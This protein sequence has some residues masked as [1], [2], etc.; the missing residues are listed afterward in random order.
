MSDDDFN[1]LN[2]IQPPEPSPEAKRRAIGASLMAFDAAEEA[3]KKESAIPPQGLSW[4]ERLKSIVPHLK[5]NWI[6]DARLSI[7]TAALVLVLLPL[8][9]QLYSTTAL[10]QPHPVDIKTPPVVTT[11]PPV[12]QPVTTPTQNAHANNDALPSTPTVPAGPIAGKDESGAAVTAN[13]QPPTSGDVAKPEP[14]PEPMMEKPSAPLAKTLNEA[15][16]QP[17]NTP[18]LAD[19]DTSTANLPTDGL[20][21]VPATEAGRAQASVASGGEADLAAAPPA[22]AQ[23]SG[24][25]VMDKSMAA[26]TMAIGARQAT[27]PT[28]DKFANFTES[29]QKAVA[30]DP[31]STFSIDVDTASYSYMRRSL[32]EGRIPEPDAVRVEELLNYFPYDYPAATSA[33]TPFKPTIAVFPTPWNSKTELMQIGIKGYEPP[34]SARPVSNLVFLIDTSGSMDEPDKLPLLQRALTL[35]VNTLPAEDTVSIVSYAGAAGVVLEPTKASDKTKILNALDNLEAG[36]STAGAEGIELAYQ[37]AEAH[38]L[39]GGNNRVILATDGDFNVGI[40]DPAAL[41]TFIKA[42]RQS[43][44]SLSV[45]GFGEGN[46]DD[47]T[48][49]ALAQNG[50]G[51]ASYIDT[52]SE[53]Q[54]VLVKEAG[55][56]LDTIA[57]DVKI[58]VEFNPA[59]V[60]S[61]RL[62]GYET[63]ALNREDFNNDKVDAGDVGAGHTV[64]ALYEI[65]PAGA[66]TT[67]PVDPLRYGSNNAATP[68]AVTP[69]DGK[70]GELA[71]FKLR[72][73]L[74]GSDTSRLIEQPVGPSMVVDNIGNA[75]T[76]ARWATAVAAFGQ[77]L[78]GSDYAGTMSY[79]DIGQLARG[80][81]GTDEDGYRSEF[82]KLV[83]LAS[84][85]SGPDKPSNTDVPLDKPIVN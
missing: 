53:A 62:I 71:D 69:A 34:A 8:G 81:K 45:L 83:G 22:S 72:Y 38:K 7:G 2:A 76:E 16:A 13:L 24:G 44:I 36:G 42:K 40:S 31:V 43:G 59:T 3:R 80:A 65:T 37:L 47:E 82:I 41:K 10:T 33:D 56:T 21:P 63:R 1:S 12:L 52:L 64:T 50:D 30:T 35:L 73:K 77:K 17:V 57:K 68:A 48:M 4:R 58:Q 60:S 78:R 19:A 55:S 79:A 49:Q 46:L 84:A 67:P 39:D 51:N 14:K 74:P 27:T 26:P 20:A 66:G 5:G 75:S 28:G 70:N 61:Y 32:E 6:M 9:Y 18:A 54:K 29:A 23:V 85:L 11:T 25:I 15:P